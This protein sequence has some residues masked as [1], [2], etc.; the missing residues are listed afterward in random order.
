MARI[1][2]AMTEKSEVSD[3]LRLS[4]LGFAR[5]AGRVGYAWQPH[6][7]RGAHR[8]GLD[9]HH[10]AAVGLGEFAGDGEAEAGAVWAARAGEGLEEPHLHALGHA[11]AVVGHADQAGLVALVE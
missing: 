11:G 4:R 5:C 1:N 8:A 9:Q 10:V 3:A 6:L 2:R 7:E